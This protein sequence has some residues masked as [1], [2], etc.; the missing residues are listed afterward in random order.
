MSVY[1]LNWNNFCVNMYVI[2]TNYSL[3]NYFLD[4]V[5]VQKIRIVLDVSNL[6]FN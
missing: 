2:L 4:T 1:F 3:K 5:R 6:K